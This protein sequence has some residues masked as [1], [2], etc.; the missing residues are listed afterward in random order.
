MVF[1]GI[2]KVAPK[3]STR[4]VVTD[5]EGFKAFVSDAGCKTKFSVSK[6]FIHLDISRKY[7]ALAG[8]VNADVAIENGRVGIKSMVAVA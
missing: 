4:L 2:V 7:G 8:N 3:G 6:G 1:T 5:T